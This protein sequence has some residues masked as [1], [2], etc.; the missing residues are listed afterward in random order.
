MKMTKPVH[1]QAKTADVRCVDIGGSL[2][3]DYSKTIFEFQENLRVVII[4]RERAAVG[5]ENLVLAAEVIVDVAQSNACAL[6][7]ITH[8][9]LGEALTQEHPLGYLYNLLA[10]I[11]LFYLHHL[12]P[13]KNEQ[14]SNL[15]TKKRGLTLS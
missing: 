11:I 5:M 10:R 9:S 13:F 1:K 15:F 3:R 4:D 14:Y 2:V 8:R 6:G 7:N 12:P